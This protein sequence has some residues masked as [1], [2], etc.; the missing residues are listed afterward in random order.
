MLSRAATRTTT[1]LV[2]KRGF[3]T[4]R[5]RMS[6]PYH[7]PEG[8][9]SNIPFNPRS[10]WF[11]VGYWTFMATGFFAPFGIAGAWFLSRR[12]PIHAPDA[13]SQRSLADLQA[14]VNLSLTD[15][16]CCLIERTEALRRQNVVYITEIDI[17]HSRLLIR[18]FVCPNSYIG[19]MCEKRVLI[20]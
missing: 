1:S 13:N 2:T 5:A 18:N 10:K 3:Q 19:V 8:A 7:Y 6:S 4:T 15:W 14:P 9:Y 16:V 11:G 12:L 17:S 20:F